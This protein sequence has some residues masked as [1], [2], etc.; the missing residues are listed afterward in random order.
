MDVVM[1][2]I[3]SKVE[4]YILKMKTVCQGLPTYPHMLE[5]QNK[6]KWNIV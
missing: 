5:M 1:N 3:Q 4:T 2:E 6:T